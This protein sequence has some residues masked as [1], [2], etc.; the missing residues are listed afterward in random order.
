MTGEKDAAAPPCHHHHHLPLINLR[1]Q[2][3][4]RSEVSKRV[5]LKILEKHRHHPYHPLHLINNK[6]T[7]KTRRM[8][9][10]ATKKAIAQMLKKYLSI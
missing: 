8:I 7:R 5:I 4:I 1:R 9:I 6:I 2:K 3:F 10:I